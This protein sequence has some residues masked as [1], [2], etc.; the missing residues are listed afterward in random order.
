MRHTRPLLFLLL[1]LLLPAPA[2]TR[3]AALSWSPCADDD[4]AQ[5]GTLGNLAV[6]RRPATSS[7]IGTLIVNP[8]GP[9]GSGVDFVLGAE[10]FFS[11]AVRA[12]FDILGFDPRVVSRIR[13]VRCTSVL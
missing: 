7:R 5:C 6:A 11:A 2:V 8:G 10:R 3:V 4:T 1:M 12:C 9:G 13:P